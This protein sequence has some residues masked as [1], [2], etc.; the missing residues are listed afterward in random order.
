MS[1]RTDVAIVG[2]GP[3]G[4]WAAYRLARSGARV[5]IFDHSHPRE[6][7]CGGGVTGRALGLT[8]DALATREV[9]AVDVAGAEFQQDG[10]QPARVAFATA[11]V[12]PDTALVV[13]DRRTFDAALLDAAVEVG[14]THAAER[15]VDV[16]VGPDGATVRTRR[17]THRCGWVIGADGVNSLVRRRLRAPF[18][19]S[20]ISV[21]TGVFVDGVSAADIVVRFVDEPPGYIWSFPRRDHLAIGACAQ[22]DSASP[23]LLRRVLDEWLASAP[24]TGSAELR[25]YSW[26]VPSLSEAT[27]DREVAAG[28]RWMLV[29]DAAGLVD[30][31]TREGIFFAL[32]S[33]GYAA[34]AI[35]QNGPAA[36]AYLTDLRRRVYPELRRA[37]RLKRG[38]FTGAFTRLLVD[39]LGRSRPVQDVMADL[40]AGRQPYGTL[41]R[42]LLATFELR[43]AWEL[44]GLERARRRS[45]G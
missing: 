5:V 28:D 41:K 31:I 2:G 16:T 45:R 33:G 18:A 15:V 40:V 22:A 39:A 3:A 34:D 7:P 21:T 44:L 11:G 12:G 29:G 14:A 1:H 8:A 27:I 35:A 4:A 43:L 37:A 38:F 13:V 20:D 10:R 32:L 36:S 23:R 25:P 6:K 24:G 19:R 30:P 42:R 17:H 26:P 9:P